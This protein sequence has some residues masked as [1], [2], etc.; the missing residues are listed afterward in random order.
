[1][2][3]G[4]CGPTRTGCEYSNVLVALLPQV[5]ESSLVFVVPL[6]TM[7]SDHPKMCW[8]P[9]PHPNKCVGFPSHTPFPERFS[10]RPST[11]AISG[12]PTNQ[13]TPGETPTICEYS[14][15]V[16]APLQKSAEYLRVFV[17]PFKNIGNILIFWVP[18]AR[19][20]LNIRGFRRWCAHHS[21][22]R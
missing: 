8:L 22:K 18:H 13:K 15:V 6:A 16:G 3:E 4:F 14:E 12:R 21:K 19:K 10:R 7:R 17:A 9:Q 5:V 11:S 1:M 2:F 20:A